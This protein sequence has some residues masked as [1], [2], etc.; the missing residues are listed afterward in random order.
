[1]V[2]KP[3]EVA[4]HLLLGRSLRYFYRLV[5]MCVVEIDLPLGKPARQRLLYLL[6]IP[7]WVQTLVHQRIELLYHLKVL[8]K[9]RF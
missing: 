4:K 7:M 8:E 1:M 9:S 6:E 3:W 2:Q 5:Q